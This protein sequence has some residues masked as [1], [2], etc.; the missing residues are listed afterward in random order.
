MWGASTLY[1]ITRN[2]RGGGRE[3]VNRYRSIADHERLASLDIIMLQDGTSDCD[4]AISVIAKQQ[5][6]IKYLR[7]HIRVAYNQRESC[8]PYATDLLDRFPWL[9]DEI[10]RLRRENGELELA[11]SSR[12]DACRCKAAGGTDG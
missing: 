3:N 1:S 11:L 6:E 8:D 2:R 9:A 12:C 5:A 4:R 7:K 10:E